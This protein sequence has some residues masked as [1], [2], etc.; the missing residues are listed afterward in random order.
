MYDQSARQRH[1]HNRPQNMSSMLYDI[2]V[3]WLYL[4]MT[5]FAIM[6]CLYV[7]HLFTFQL[8]IIGLI[9]SCVRLIETHFWKS[10]FCLCLLAVVTYDRFEKKRR[11]RGR[12]DIYIDRCYREQER[13]Q[14]LGDSSTSKLKQ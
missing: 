7:I 5:A 8:D 10:I 14:Y 13:M 12:F 3:D 6:V 1:H 2:L 11:E 9:G 4:L